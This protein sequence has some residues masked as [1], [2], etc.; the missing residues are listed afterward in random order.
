M[1]F[2]AFGFGS[3]IFP[4]ECFSYLKFSNCFLELRN[5]KYGLQIKRTDENKPLKYSATNAQLHKAYLI[6]SSFNTLLSS[7]VGFAVLLNHISARRMVFYF[8]MTSPVKRHSLTCVTGQKQLRL[9]RRICQ[10]VQTRFGM[11]LISLRHG[12]RDDSARQL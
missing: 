12:D 10:F 2:L 11:T 5:F 7:F 6:F 9:V 1:R 3:K 4:R 8:C